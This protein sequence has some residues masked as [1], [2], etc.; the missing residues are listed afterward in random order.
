MGKITKDMSL[1]ELLQTYPGAKD[2]LARYGMGCLG[3]MGSTMETIEGGAR[4]HGID[5]RNLLDELSC[6]EEKGPE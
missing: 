2:I 4:M 5:L 3:C 6:L 1:M